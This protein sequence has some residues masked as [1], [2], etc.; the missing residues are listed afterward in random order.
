MN[1]KRIY[2]ALLVLLAIAIQSCSKMNDLTD[3]YLNEGEIVYAAK[4]DS[5]GILSG[6]NRMQ[7]DLVIKA[8]RI[9]KVRIY[10]NNYIDSI[11]VVIGG[12]TGIFPVKLDNMP[13]GGY[14]FQVVS[15]DKFGNRSLQLEATGSSYG[16]DYKRTLSNRSYISE[17]TRYDMAGDSMV[18]YWGGTVR[19][20]I[21]MKLQ[22][23]DIS[24]KIVQVEV[25]ADVTTTTLRKLKGNI[26][27][28]SRFVPTVNAI[29][30]FATEPNS[31][32]VY[33]ERPIDKKG[34]KIT[35]FSSASPS[36][37]WPATNAIDGDIN[38]PWHTAHNPTAPFPH[39]FIVDMGE[40]VDISSFEVY[41]RMDDSGGAQP[42]HQIFYAQTLTDPTKSDDAGWKDYGTYPF[43]NVVSIPQFSRGTQVV[44]ARYFMYYVGSNTRS[45]YAYIGEIGAYTPA[46]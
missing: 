16:E 10:W 20:S 43:D 12:G 17:Y 23:T 41:R 19:G 4:V 27:Y 5:V 46:N 9:D 2:L 29:D 35:A 36:P 3:E 15:F 28:N 7:L 25:P 22:Y 44:K 8:Q 6:E 18:I 21:G 40:V 24:D 31:I 11:D 26:S 42:T 14:L 45:A 33:Y 34:W 32:P 13:E 1:Y 30:T 38:T 37:A 39:Y